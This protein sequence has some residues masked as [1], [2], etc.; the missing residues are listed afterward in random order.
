MTSVE[1]WLKGELSY[2]STWKDL[3]GLSWFNWQ[4]WICLSV[5]QEAKLSSDFLRMWNK[6]RNMILK[7]CKIKCEKYESGRTRN[8]SRHQEQGPSEKQTVACS[9]LLLR[10]RLLSSWFIATWHWQCQWSLIMISWFNNHEMFVQKENLSTPALRMKFPV[11]FHFRAKIGPWQRDCRNDIWWLIGMQ[12]YIWAD[13]IPCDWSTFSTL[14]CPSVFSSL[15]VVLQI[16]KS[17]WYKVEKV[18]QASLSNWRSS[19]FNL[20]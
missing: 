11:L 14:C 18:P 15:P 7:K 19:N 10:P 8:T 6:K 12:I 13:N 5:E 17:R 3:T 9:F 4:T 1:T 2:L 16:L 20:T